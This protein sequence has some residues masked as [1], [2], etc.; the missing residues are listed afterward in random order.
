ITYTLSA[1]YI[2]IMATIFMRVGP[3][4][5]GAAL[6]LLLNVYVLFVQDTGGSTDSELSSTFM[7]YYVLI[8]MI[9]YFVVRSSGFLMKDIRTQ[10]EKA[11][12]ALEAQQRQET[13]VL[14]TVNE[15]SG[16]LTAISKAGDD[17]N[18]M[19]E[20]M[21]TAFRDI[22]AG[23]S[24]QAESTAEIA[25]AVQRTTQLIDTM[26]DSLGTLQSM[27]GTASGQAHAGQDK[28]DALHDTIT[29]FRDSIGRMAEDIQSL[30]AMIQTAAQFSNSVEEIA[31]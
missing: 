2:L 26:L 1:Y 3:Y 12:T 14:T 11:V 4:L 6:G 30:N 19:F 13:L 10:A 25:E 7:I 18:A 5:T 16:H 28:M 21:S 15:V 31:A 24:G 8:A 29:E 22:A 9:I 17:N 23:A 27:A 20:H